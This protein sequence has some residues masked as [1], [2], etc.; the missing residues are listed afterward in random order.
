[1]RALALAVATAL[2]VAGCSSTLPADTP[3]PTH[4]PT[5]TA[6]APAPTPSPVV[7]GSIAISGSGLDTLVVDAPVAPVSLSIDALNLS[8]PVESVGVENNG[9]M[10][11]P[12]S[13][14][15]AGWYRFGG[16]PLESDGN[17]VMAA[18]VDDAVIGLGPFARLREASVG[19]QIEVALE[20]GTQVTYEVTQ[21][22]QTSK[23]TVDLEA[24][25]ATAST[26]QLVL[27]TCG[28]NFDWDSRHY[29]DNVMVWAEL[30]GE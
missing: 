21:I 5:A 10:E 1:M 6:V 30:A 25:F 29:V 16:A 9:E 27:V 2:A 17:V 8:M 11:I 23:E 18:H 15:T 26:N 14:A 19:D 3:S 13:A 4:T 22:E 7:T 12:E 28:G 20:D 24:V